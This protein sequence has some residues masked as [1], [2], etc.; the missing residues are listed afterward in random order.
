VPTDAERCAPN[1]I[2]MCLGA[3]SEQIAAQ[4]FFGRLRDAARVVRSVYGQWTYTHIPTFANSKTAAEFS[5]RTQ[6]A[7]IG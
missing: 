2:L 3:A 4:T 5:T 1:G 6:P 7:V